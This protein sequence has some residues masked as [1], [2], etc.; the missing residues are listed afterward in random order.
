M[1]IGHLAAWAQAGGASELPGLAV[2]RPTLEDTY[3]RLIAAH[4][5]QEA[6]TE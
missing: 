2:A 1:I 3:L 6:V 4:Q 5:P